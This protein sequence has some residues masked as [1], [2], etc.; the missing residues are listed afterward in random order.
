MRRPGSPRRY[1][2]KSCGTG[3][4]TNGGSRCATS[5]GSPRSTC[6]SCTSPA[7]TTMSRS[8]LRPTSPPWSIPS[9]ANSAA[10]SARSSSAKVVGDPQLDDG[11]LV[12]EFKAPPIGV[13]DLFLHHAQELRQSGSLLFPAHG[14]LRN[15]DDVGRGDHSIYWPP[16]Q[17]YG[18]LRPRGSSSRAIDTGSTPNSPP[19]LSAG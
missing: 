8:A 12:A 7:G 18:R 13:K 6:P 19:R 1:G 3:P 14:A 2:A 4:W 10:G 15:N 5:T 16:V 9:W 17:S 11:R